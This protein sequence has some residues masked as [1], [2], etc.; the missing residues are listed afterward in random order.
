MVIT[1]MDRPDLIK[2]KDLITNRESLVHASWLRPL[3]HP[4][5]MSAEKIKSLIA[6]DL[7]EFYVEKIIPV[8]WAV[9]NLEALDDYSKDNPHLN[10]GRVAQGLY[11]PLSTLNEHPIR[12]I[13]YQILWGMFWVDDVAF[14][15]QLIVIAYLDLQHLR[16][17]FLLD[18]EHTHY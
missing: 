3:K 10:L 7:D 6:A 5:D 2:V 14:K 11:K 8:D 18:P 16:T 12:K 9:K 17:A 13:L 1:V 15:T 4:K